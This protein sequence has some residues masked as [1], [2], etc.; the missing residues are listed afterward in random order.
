MD[1]AVKVVTLEVPSQETVEMKAAIAGMEPLQWTEMRSLTVIELIRIL[2]HFPADA[3]VIVE[4]GEF[5]P[6]IDWHTFGGIR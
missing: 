3:K 5:T 2:V 4:A 6:I 1:E